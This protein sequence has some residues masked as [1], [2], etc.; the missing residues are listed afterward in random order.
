VEESSPGRAANEYQVRYGRSYNYC[1]V[2]ENV[3]DNKMQYVYFAVIEVDGHGLFISRYYY[4][5]IWRRA[6]V[7]IPDKKP[8]SEKLV[9]LASV[10]GYDGSPEELLHPGWDEEEEEWK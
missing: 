8:L 2:E 1:I 9:D 7:R 4:S 5:R 3:A 6:G 10:L